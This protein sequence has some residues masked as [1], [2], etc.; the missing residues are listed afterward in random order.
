DAS[1][2]RVSIA[3]GARR[4][5]ARRHAIDFRFKPIQTTCVQHARDRNGLRRQRSLPDMPR[6]AIP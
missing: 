2:N 4:T 3:C 1:S 6:H 5:T